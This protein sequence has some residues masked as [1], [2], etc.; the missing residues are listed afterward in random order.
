[1]T[2]TA[3]T[4][5][6]AIDFQRVK[7]DSLLRNMASTG[8]ADYFSTFG[9][10][11]FGSAKRWVNNTQFTSASGMV[12]VDDGGWARVLSAMDTLYKTAKDTPPEKVAWVDLSAISRLMPPN[13]Q[14]DGLGSPTITPITT[15]G[16]NTA[17]VVIPSE[18]VDTIN[19]A[20]EQANTPPSLDN[21]QGIVLPVDTLETV[22]DE[23]G[24]ELTTTQQP[25]I[26]STGGTGW[27]A[28]APTT[29]KVGAV[30][31]GGVGLL[32]VLKLLK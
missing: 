26:T 3:R 18:T 21:E 13:F 28:T 19:Q 25:A 10:N 23:T 8:A 12:L 20:Q 30:A 7:F 22:G 6:L 31:A 32:L 5:N 17:D 11:L 27:W 29:H 9:I 4:A 2:I 15:S 1:M 16:S 14:G 24:S